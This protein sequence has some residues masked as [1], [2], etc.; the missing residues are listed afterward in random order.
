[1]DK[2]L[3]QRIRERAYELWTQH[4]SPTDGAD[5]YWYQAEREIL[6]DTAAE[7]TTEVGALTVPSG[8]EQASHEASPAPL[9]MTSETTDETEVAPAAA[10]TRKK[11]TPAA[12]APTDEGGAAG[13]APKRRRSAR[14]T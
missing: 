1:M 13:E 9:G 4:G 3:E 11:R 6:G 14:A 8:E 10:K 2:Q 5:E 12:A 7:S